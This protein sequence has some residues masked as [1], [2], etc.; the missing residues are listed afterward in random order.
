MDTSRAAIA[1]WPVARLRC[2][3]MARRIRSHPEVLVSTPLFE[4]AIQDAV[5][6]LRDQPAESVDLLITDPAYE[7]LE[8]HRAVGH[9]HSAEAQQVIEQRLVQDFPQ[10]AVRGAVCRGISRASA[11]HALL[12]VLRRRDDVCRQAGGRACGVPV[13]EAARV[14]QAHHRHGL[15]LPGPLRV[16]PVLRKGEAPSERPRHSGRDLDSQ[17]PWRLP[18]REACRRVGDPDRPELHGR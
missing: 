18:G 4:L 10:R 5:S 11:Q 17:N 9:D 3:R 15:P 2:R 1:R 14:G 12:P 8:K 13:L 16:H 6:W 7:S